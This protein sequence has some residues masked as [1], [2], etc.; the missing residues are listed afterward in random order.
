MLKLIVLILGT[1]SVLSLSLV[2]TFG[3][4]QQLRRQSTCAL[5]ATTGGANLRGA[6]GHR[7]DQTRAR[8]R[9][10]RESVSSFG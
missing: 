2:G 1:W 7:N 9:V 4:L 5:G 3:F 8:S 10:E 6:P